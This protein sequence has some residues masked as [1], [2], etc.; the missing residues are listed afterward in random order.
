[1]TIGVTIRHVGN[2]IRVESPY[3]PEFPGKARKH[4]SAPPKKSE[5]ESPQ[6]RGEN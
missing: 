2:D 5:D 6:A 4:G 1:M 3:H